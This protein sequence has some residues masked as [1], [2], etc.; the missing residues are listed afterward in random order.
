MFYKFYGLVPTP[1]WELTKL[2]KIIGDN[3]DKYCQAYSHT[4]QKVEVLLP[5][6]R[7]GDTPIRLHLSG[8]HT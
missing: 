3:T 7:F 4:T 1:L 6:L 8:N 2:V 5:H